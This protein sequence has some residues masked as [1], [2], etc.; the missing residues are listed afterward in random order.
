MMPEET[1]P[2]F[3]AMLRQARERRGLSLVALAGATRISVGVLEAL[4]RNDLS[5]LPGG[6]FTRAF[7]RAYAK[8]VGLDPHEAVQAFVASF[9][10]ED[11]AMRHGA[12]KAPLRPDIPFESGGVGRRILARTIAVLVAGVVVVAYLAWS[13]RLDSWR[14]PGAATVPAVQAP[15]QAPPAS[16]AVR[17]PD[18]PP[19]VSPPPEQPVVSPFADDPGLKAAAAGVGAVSPPP[20]P[21]RPESVLRLTLVAEDRCWVSV[22]SDGVRVLGATMEAGEQREVEVGG[23][24]SLTA[25]NAGVFSYA[26]NGMPARPMGAAGQVVTVIITAQNYK[27]FLQSE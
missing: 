9:P 18:T 14:R 16:V 22:R 1:S 21:A 20:G 25:G 2:D 24:I 11:E 6:I 13:G 19:A 15:E 3:G 5:R 4:E 7:V 8:E 10:S 26:I 23:R 27:T 17:P 12:P